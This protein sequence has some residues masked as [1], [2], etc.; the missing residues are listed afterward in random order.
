MKLSVHMNHSK[1]QKRRWE[2][3]GESFGTLLTA[4][5][6]DPE[7]AADAYLRLRRNLER[8]FD[9]RGIRQ[10]DTATDTT[11]DRLARKLAGGEV[12]ADPHTYALGI[13]RMIVLEIRKSPE[14]RTA[15]LP[16]ISFCDTESSDDRKEAGLECLDICLNKL[17]AE[18]REAIIGYY[19]GKQ[20]EK[21]KN[22]KQL[23]ERFGIPANALRN[24]AVR[25]RNKLEVCIRSCL[26]GGSKALF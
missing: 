22:R 9:V 19:Q 17:S 21:I 24:R 1:E 4:L 7:Y 20:S 26:K 15:E 5:S 25:I 14:S 2:L 23:A 13:A 3:D 6:D 8:F 18:S 10:S 12:I 16:E 11:L